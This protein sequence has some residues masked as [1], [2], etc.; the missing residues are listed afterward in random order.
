M[1]KEAVARTQW[2]PKLIDDCVATQ[3]AIL[4]GVW[5]A[6]RPGGVLLYST[7]TF[8]PFEDERRI[9]WLADEF[10]AEPLDLGLAGEWGI[11]GA[12]EG[13]APCARFVPGH[14]RGEGLFLAAVRKPDGPCAPAARGGRTRHQRQQQPAADARRFEAWTTRDAGP[15]TWQWSADGQTLSA[16][17]EIHAR[18]IELICSRATTLRAGVEVAQ[19]KGRSA[20]PAHALAM[21]TLLAPEAFATAEVDLAT[22]LSYLRR[23]TITLPSATPR[24]I[25]LLTH[26]GHPLGFANNLGNRANNL[27][28]QQWRI[29]SAARP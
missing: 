24:G 29:L 19:M 17:P 22:A 7:C 10:G 12:I 18:E 14:I 5:Q 28:P 23:E 2:S 20:I 6:L 3:R 4:K 15:L 27:Y 16:L 9:A 26:G 11:D 1:R 13:T 8:N 21:S 25:V